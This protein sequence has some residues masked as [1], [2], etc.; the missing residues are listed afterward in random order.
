M[1]PR[2]ITLLTDF[3]LEDEYVG[4]MKGVILS[5]FPAARLVDLSHRI[6]PQDLRRAAYL[7][8]SSRPF[9]PAGT[10]HVAVVDPGVGTS[11][12]VILVEAEGQL[13]LAPD[14][15]LLTLQIGGNF[16]AA[17]EVSCRQLFLQPVSNTFHGRD[18]F[19]PVAAE[20]AKGMAPAGVGRPLP[21]EDLITFSFPQAVLDP[22]TSTIRGQVVSIDHFGN[23]LTNISCQVYRQLAPDP[24][25]GTTEVQVRDRIIS[26]LATSYDGAPPGTL[27]AI[28]GSR[29]F[30]EI[31]VN[32]GNACR[33]LAAAPDEKIEVR[34]IQAKRR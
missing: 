26:G 31:A 23:L 5:R 12:R 28:F 6:P 21:R 8:E 1:T 17:Y 14:N 33:E 20:L 25:T 29:N 11:R 4:V 10:L 18:I 24:A 32:R 13:F 16:S 22:A 2:L 27:L 19:A 7:L 30:L 3:G 9:F 34:V 15:G